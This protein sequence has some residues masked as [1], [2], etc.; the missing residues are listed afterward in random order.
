MA[1]GGPCWQQ[2]LPTRHGGTYNAILKNDGKLLERNKPQTGD[3]QDPGWN[4]QATT[5]ALCVEPE[6]NNQGHSLWPGRSWCRGDWV[7]WQ[8]RVETF[9]KDINSFLGWKLTLALNEMNSDTGSEWSPGGLEADVCSKR[10]GGAGSERSPG[11]VGG[12]RLPGRNGVDTPEV[13]GHLV[14]EHLGQIG[15]H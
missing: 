9:I 15:Q 10:C 14:I 12:R 4:W 11:W 6:G 3:S 5:M 7:N 1:L 2:K 8:R 13:K